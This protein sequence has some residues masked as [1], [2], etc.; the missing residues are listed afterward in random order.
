MITHV[1]IHFVK[2]IINH[3]LLFGDPV[4]IIKLDRFRRLAVFKPQSI[5]GYIRWRANNFG[6]IDWKLYVVKSG[7]EGLMTQVRGISPAVK[8][9]VS[10]SG[11]DP[12]KRGL[13]VMDDIKAQ[14]KNGLIGVP[15]SYW[16][17]VHTSLL[18]RKPVHE[19]PRHYRKE[20][21]S[22]AR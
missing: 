21:L 5:F 1:Q 8:L 15:E 12:M 22:H 7:T 9:L 2:D 10:V 19:L 16:Q 18:L 11:R 17:A 6:T 14:S 20:A 3:R 13:A 4:E